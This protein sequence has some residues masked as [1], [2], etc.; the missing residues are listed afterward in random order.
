MCGE[1]LRKQAEYFEL[2]PSTENKD[3]SKAALAKL[4]QDAFGD[5]GRDRVNLI[6]YG[7]DTYDIG[8]NEITKLPNE[9]TNLTGQKIFLYDDEKVQ[10]SEE[11]K[12]MVTN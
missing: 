12:K 6:P 1:K 4:G 9:I 11:Q 5:K 10:S 3:A 7:K 2:I 8:G